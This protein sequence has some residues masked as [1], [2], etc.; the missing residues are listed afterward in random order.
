[1]G[2]ERVRIPL[3]YKVEEIYERIREAIETAPEAQR[4][5]LQAKFLE[6]CNEQAAHAKQVL[7]AHLSAATGSFRPY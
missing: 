1:M 6:L 3:P 4:P 7:D 5:M 2:L